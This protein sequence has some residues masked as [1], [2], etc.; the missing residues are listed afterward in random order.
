MSERRMG[1]LGLAAAA[2]VAAGLVVERKVVQ[3]R[4]QAARDADQLG[5]LHSAPRQV[6]ADDGV[7]LHAEIDEI[8]PYT[9]AETDP[10]LPTLVFAHG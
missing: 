4:R 8:A 6:I 1:L 7:V 3:E 9:S 5:T 2:A 10:D